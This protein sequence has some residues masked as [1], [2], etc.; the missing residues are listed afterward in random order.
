MT[1]ITHTEYAIVSR[2][3]GGQTT[4]EVAREAGV[5]QSRVSNV[6]AHA[7]SRVPGLDV[8]L[9]VSRSLA[10]AFSSVS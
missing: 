4:N 9:T 3:L 10:K 1:P 2:L 6:T 8:A 5:S 7:C